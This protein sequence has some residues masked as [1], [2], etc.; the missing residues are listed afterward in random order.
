MA[1]NRALK[2]GITNEYEIPWTCDHA[3]AVDYDKI[4]DLY[5]TEV[6]F[7]LLG[8][9]DPSQIPI[10]KVRYAIAEAHSRD[11]ATKVVH[12]DKLKVKKFLA[13]E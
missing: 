13:G 2:L 12:R 1:H 11:F 8:I 3:G 9:V 5:R 6:S 7:R 10:M 4:C